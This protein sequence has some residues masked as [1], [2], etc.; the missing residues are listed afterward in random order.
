VTSGTSGRI[1][2]AIRI[3]IT[4]GPSAVSAAV[5]AFDLVGGVR[6][7]AGAAESLGGANDIE[8]RKIKSWNVGR[9]LENRK[10]LE[11]GILVVARHDEDEL[12]FLLGRGIQTLHRVL[13]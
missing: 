1:R 9:L 4:L 3:A 11:N 10:V 5:N 12:E 7:D 13:K 6:C 8:S 2:R